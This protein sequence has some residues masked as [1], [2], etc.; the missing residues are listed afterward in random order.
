MKSKIITKE[1]ASDRQTPLS[2]YQ[3]VGGVGC[4]MLESIDD[5]KISIIGIQPIGTFLARD[6][7]I[8][9]E[10]HGKRSVYQ[11]DPYSELRRFAADRKAFGFLG[12][13]AIRLNEKLPDRHKQGDLHDFFFH[14]YQTII[15]FDYDRKTIVFTHEGT[16]EELDAICLRCS[17]S[18]DP[19]VLQ[20]SKKVTIQADI[21]REEFAHMVER[22]QE[23]I[24]AG[25]VFQVVLSRTFRSTVQAKAF[26]VYR[27]L[28]QSSPAPYLFFFEEPAFAVAGASPELLISV[29]DGVVESMPIAGTCS[30]ENNFD[31]LSDPKELAEHVM[32][33]DLARNDV[34]RIAQ[35][36]SVRVAESMAIR[37]F[38]HLRHIVS[39]VVGT[40]NPSLHALDALRAAFPAGTLSGAPKIRAMEIIDE[41]ENRRRGLYGG[42]IVSMDER[43]NLKSCIAIRMI[44]L[45]DGIAEVRAGAGIVLESNPQKEAMETEI[46]AKGALEALMLLEACNDLTHR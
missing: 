40:L 12:Y 20:N 44:V 46:K 27:A 31:L 18:I 33:V 36:G 28:R 30:N 39:R 7:T 45:Q 22:A 26:D 43:G 16:Q 10:R 8:E 2:C 34:G 38:S 9:I 1:I 32:L 6:D 23:Y 29:Q 5:G 13:D 17:E 21:S 35:V 37:S 3:A 4:C 19:Q 14:I 42:A 24:R 25:D 11:G 15:R 41:L